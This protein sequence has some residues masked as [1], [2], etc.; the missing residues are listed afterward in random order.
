[1]ASP[2]ASTIAGPV[3]GSRIGRPPQWT[4]SRSRK[5][6]R[7]Y[8][9]ST[10]SLEK[11]IKVLEDDGFSP[12]K[13][14]AQKTIHKIL[15]NDPRYLRP[16]SRVEM[17]KRINSLA[18]SPRRQRRK[19]ARSRRTTTVLDFGQVNLNSGC[20]E[21]SSR[22][23]EQTLQ[24]GQSVKTEDTA[25]FHLTTPPVTF[26]TACLTFPTPRPDPTEESGAE[27]YMA[28]IQDIKRRVSNCSTQFAMQLSSLV[29]E[30]TISVCSDDRSS[31]RRPSAAL[32]EGSGPAELPNDN[33]ATEPYEPFPDP[34]FALPGDFLTAHTRS[35]AD[36]PGQPHGGGNCWCS[37]AKHTAAAPNSWL[38]PTGEL[39]DRA[40]HVLSQPSPGGLS[41]RDSF[42]N[43][44]LH[45]FAALDGYQDRLL[46][47]V[48]SAR[49]SGEL[50]AV[51]T[52]VQT[53]LH[54]LNLEW[55]SDLSN[56]SAPL[57]QLLAHVVE[58]CPGL[59]HETDVYGRTFFHRA[60]SLLRD[61][62]LLAGL[63]SAFDPTLVTRRDAFGFSPVPDPAAASPSPYIP[64]RRMGSPSPQV[65]DN[66]A[67]ASPS[68]RPKS[69]TSEGSLLAYHARLVQVI[70][71]SYTNPSIEDADGRNG[72]HCLAEAILDQQ[73]MDRHVRSSSS[74]SSGS[75]PNLKRKKH[76]SREPSGS[77]AAVT[78]T[79]TTV[80]AATAGTTTSTITTTVAAVAAANTTTATATKMTKTASSSPPASAGGQL[81]SS[82]I[83]G[84]G[85]VEGT[86]PTRLRHLHSLLHPS[87]S[88]SVSHYDRR[89]YTPLMAFIEHVS[90]DQDD[91][92][93]TLQAILEALV[94][95]GARLEA[96]NR[97]GETPL[98]LAARL[99]R[100][101]ALA[102]LLEGGA[103][104]HARDA[105]GRGLLELL[106]A[107][108][109]GPRARAHVGLYARLEA[110]RV[111]L[112]GRRGWGV[113]YVHVGEPAVV[114]EWRMRGV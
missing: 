34:G 44:P 76:E 94:R 33:V 92:A 86:L 57:R 2:P 11:I 102:T 37:I 79:T 72:L 39:S 8:L 10:L 73:A 41:L 113:G 51:N 68:S 91:K 53:F 109:C 90:D 7:L 106:D 56:P 38:L 88:V 1:M 107:E 71:S 112:T 29:R 15:D 98:L 52:A 105:D 75:R 70:Q 40:R 13:N 87:V 49:S 23:S 12:R 67:R 3:S 28:G 47:M 16:E 36:F 17:S 42:G 59:V 14:S 25:S 32:S 77:A 58:H 114:R 50:A 31:G 78:T 24:S 84:G 22:R 104:A 61:Q 103:N 110:C 27:S 20:R 35:C 82:P 83:G 62:A 81:S 30:F 45:L 99:G 100:K 97:R 54:V 48:L 93:R 95:A 64:P 89:G 96:R 60:H 111:L 63:V 66:I 18:M 108:V 9:Y 74:S 4:V 5:L 55:F 46:E 43:T 69:A 19:S 21:S 26:N 85:P 65:E 6:A 101:V 80:T